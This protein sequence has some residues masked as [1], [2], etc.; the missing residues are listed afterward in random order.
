MKNNP[1]SE[2]DYPE[3]DKAVAN[4]IRKTINRFRERPF[5][6]FTEADIHASLVKD[7]TSGNKKH[8]HFQ[9]IARKHNSKKSKD[10][11]MNLFVSLVH[12]EYPTNFR[13]KKSQLL[14]GYYGKEEMTDLMYGRSSNK[15]GDRG[16]FDL[17]VLN[18]HFLD[19]ITSIYEDEDLNRDGDIGGAL[20]NIVNK[21]NELAKHRFEHSNLFRREL[22]Y[23]IEVKFLHL[24]NSRHK[25]LLDEV[26]KD[27]EKLR[28]AAYASRCKTGY[29]VK[30]INLVF[31]S[32]N[33]NQA[34][35]K[36]SG[37]EDS[38]ITKVQSYIENGTVEDYDGKKYKLPPE[39][40]NILVQSYIEEGKD[41]IKKYTPKPIVRDMPKLENMDMSWAEEIKGIL[42]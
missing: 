41:S 28:L 3:I 9:T 42:S 22:L 10:R 38:V 14:E 7:I 39:V 32:S 27:N 34:R 26:I 11:K 33:E 36:K 13:Y 40:L 29:Y 16:N 19:N 12:Q 4:G 21:D 25:S 31:C 37:E 1:Y 5:F 35:K 24:F 8:L 20:R 30:P 15:H 17:A 23:A 6:Y 18:P 2:A